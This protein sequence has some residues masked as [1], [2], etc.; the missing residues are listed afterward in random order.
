MT[1][2]TTVTLL[3]LLVALAAGAQGVEFVDK[4]LDSVF[5][6]AKEQGKMVFVDCYSTHC[7]PCVKMIREEFPKKELGDYINQNF[8]AAKYNLDNEPYKQLMKQWDVHAFPTFVFL[9]ADGEVLYRMVGY[10]EAGK[11][12]AEARQGLA[13]QR[14]GRLKKQY[15]QGDRSL[16]F[17]FDYLAELERMHLG[18]DCRTVAVD[19]LCNSELQLAA[20]RQGFDVFRRYVDSPYDEVFLNAWTDRSALTAA[21]GEEADKKLHEVWERQPAHF[22]IFD[23]RDFQGYDPEKMREYGEYMRRHGVEDYKQILQ[24]YEDNYKMYLEMEKGAKP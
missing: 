5:T 21:Y 14:F 13:D 11:F 18:K 24:S 10:R 9:S 15:G 2:I 3:S 6:L 23:G 4:P 1:R 19:I 17:L 22:G 8:I 12:L 16:P 20:N 7:P